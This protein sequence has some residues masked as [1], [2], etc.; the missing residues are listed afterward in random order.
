MLTRML[1]VV[2]ILGA[3]T[4]GYTIGCLPVA[5][6]VA[7]R[8]GA[9]DLRTVGDRNP[10]YWNAHEQIGV[11]ASA[12]I[13]AGDVAKGA[14]AVVLARSMRGPW[15]VTYVAGGAAMIGH[16]FPAFDGWSGGR[17]VLTFVGAATA[18]AP[19]PAAMSVAALGATWTATH[20]FDDAARAGVAAFPFIQCALEGP[21]RTAA[22]GVLMSFIGLRFAQ[23]RAAAPCASHRQGADCDQQPSQGISEG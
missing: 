9:A 14:A 21:K 20:R 19:R 6:S 10:G 2:R 4:L 7:R 18:Y 5:N 22:S 8:H 17:S 12:P 1:P 11:R 15:W 3:A 16:A 23:A 13:F